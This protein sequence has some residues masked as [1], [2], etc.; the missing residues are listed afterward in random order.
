MIKTFKI[1]TLGCKVNQYESQEIR[2]RFIEAGYFESQNN[3]SD[4]VVINTCT[5][6]RRADSESL[7][8]VRRAVRE[9][10]KAK[11]IVT[12][13]LVELDRQKIK[14]AYRKAVILR[15][16]DKQSITSFSN[17]K[18]I[19]SKGISY[20]KGHSRA[21]LKIQD[22]CDNFCSYCKV[23]LVRGR[24]RSRPAKDIIKDAERLVENGYKEI[25]L[26]GI[27]LG[28]FGKDLKPGTD[29][30]DLI[31][32]LES[33]D[34]LLRIR[35]SSIEAADI[36]DNLIRKMFHSKKLCR[37]L[38]IPIQS[39]DDDILKQMRRKYSRKEY[40]ELIKKLRRHIPEIAITTDVLV[41]FPGETEQNFSNTADLVRKIK[42]LKVHI[43]PFSPRPGTAANELNGRIN[44][45]IVRKRILALQ[46]VANDCSENFRKKFLGR[47]ETVLI[48][49]RSKENTGFW[50]GYADTYIKVLV[51]SN[52][53]L[54]NRLISMKLNK[55]AKN[56]MI[57]KIPL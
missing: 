46:K 40:L 49:G 17:G 41:G 33:I 42:P 31:G 1:L 26:T 54:S 50:E 32:K 35:L 30:V 20:F 16:R 10:Q 12:G 43:F 3:S 23:P 24:S 28:A 22:G 53:N 13:C 5:V 52:K 45:V 27:C 39:G 57:G 55:I 21:F 9:N 2:E 14:N 19:S 4:I 47:T 51:K 44:P 38:H 6:T 11:I 25:V 34:G 18:K 56:H 37:H 29:L 48:E 8:L 15:N 36:S 7:N